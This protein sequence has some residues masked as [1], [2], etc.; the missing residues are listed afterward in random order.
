VPLASHDDDDAERIAA[1]AG[2]GVA[3]SEFPIHLEA[4]QAAAAAGLRVLLG[5]PNIVRGGSQGGN[6]RA[7][8]AFAAGCGHCLCSD[9]H[10]P[11]LLAAVFRLAEAPGWDLPRAA[12]T[13]SAVPAEAVGLRDRGVIAVGQRADLVLARWHPV[14]GSNGRP[15][16]RAAS[17]LCGGRL[18]I[19]TADRLDGELAC[20]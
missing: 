4:A 7:M 15:V 10:P 18:V 20:V 9:Y 3:V 17:V 13:A 5:A 2:L 11:S 1:F 6:M 16:A 19:D 8:D 14:V 12:A